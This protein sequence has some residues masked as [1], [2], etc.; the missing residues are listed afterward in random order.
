MQVKTLLPG[1]HQ[2]VLGNLQSH[3][4]VFLEDSDESEVFSMADRSQLEREVDACREYYEE[5]LHSAERGKPCPLTP[6]PPHPS[7][8]HLIP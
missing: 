1:D 8:H 2:L 5:L 6:L 4:D 7:Q 3:L